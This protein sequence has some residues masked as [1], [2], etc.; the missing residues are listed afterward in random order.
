MA[1]APGESASA[2]DYHWALVQSGAYQA[3]AVPLSI[4][5]P[6]ENRVWYTYQGPET[7]REG[8]VRRVKAQ[9]RVLDDGASQVSRFEYNSRGQMTKRTDPL[10]RET[11]FEYDSSGL[12]LVTVR[13][14]NGAGYDLIETRTYNGEHQPLTVTDAAGQ[15][16]TYTYNANGQ[17]LTVTNAKSETTTYSYDTS[18]Y[19]TSL[20]KPATGA[21]T[22]F[23]YDDHGRVRTAT[24]P[25][26][27]ATTT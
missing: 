7:T 22:T 3:A 14:K 5:R 6:L 17:V 27:Y 1:I 2:T 13:Q 24:D 21:T 16:T 9:G 4:K 12:D 8:T 19:L 20:T 10:G 26:S 18:G 15:T 11:V 25:D 23:T